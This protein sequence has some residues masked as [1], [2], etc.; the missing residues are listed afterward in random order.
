[1]AST[2]A[3]PLFHP[4]A[5]QRGALDSRRGMGC[6]SQMKACGSLALGEEKIREPPSII[7]PVLASFE[8]F[9]LRPASS[10][11]VPDRQL[12]RRRGATSRRQSTIVGQSLC[13]ADAGLGGGEA[14]MDF[15][16]GLI[17][18]GRPRHWQAG[19]CVSIAAR[20]SQLS[21]FGAKCH[22]KRLVRAAGQR[23]KEGFVE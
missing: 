18:R 21:C 11:S 13:V 10:A 2:A 19:T 3:G 12:T 1:M 8:Y 20:L 14:P 7:S 4:A 16:A 5:G 23:R 17:T 22:P 6:L 9:S 15:R